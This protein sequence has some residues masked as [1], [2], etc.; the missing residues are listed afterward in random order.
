MDGQCD[1]LVTVV[2]HHFITLTVHACVQHGGRKAPRRAGLPAA[3]ETGFIDS[4][5]ATIRVA[6]RP[7]VVE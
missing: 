2:G 7:P 5:N 4:V 1:K 6:I 3:A